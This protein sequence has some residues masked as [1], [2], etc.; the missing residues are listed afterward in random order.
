MCLCCTCAKASICVN[1]LLASIHRLITV[2]Y[3]LLHQPY[4]HPGKRTERSAVVRLH[5]TNP[6]PPTPPDLPRLTAATAKDQVRPL[7]TIE[8]NSVQP[9]E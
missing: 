3:Y 9:P 7:Y 4:H 5:G 6:I 1:N 8:M 2:V